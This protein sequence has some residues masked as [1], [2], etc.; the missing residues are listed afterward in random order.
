LAG[1]GKADLAQYRSL[2][3]G[4]FVDPFRVADLQRQTTPLT[5]ALPSANICWGGKTSVRDSFRA[6]VDSSLLGEPT[7]FDEADY[8]TSLRSTLFYLASLRPDGMGTGDPT[9]LKVLRC[10]DCG[11][12]PFELVDT[13]AQQYCP[14]CGSEIYPTDCLRIWEEVTDFQS[15]AEALS[16]FMTLVEHPLPFHYIRYLAT[17]SLGALGAL[18]FFV[19]GPLAV[20]GNSAWLSAAILRFVAQVNARLAHAGYPRL[21]L[22]GLQKTGQLVD[23]ANLIA[24]H[25]PDHRLFAVD[26]DYRYRYVIPNRDP[27]ERGFGDVTYC[28]QDF[29]YRT[30]SGRTFVFALP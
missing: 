30:E 10:P 20:F 6:A 7:C 22:I 25:V 18:A 19:D 29:L 2:R 3:V 16:R 27:A 15:N 4:A 5:F 23:H 28:G 1:V 24:R 21:V 26:D 11:K 13:P 17:E 12:G 14:A 9:R 8:R